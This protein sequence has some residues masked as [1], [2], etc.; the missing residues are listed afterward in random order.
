[1]QSY[2]PKFK[3]AG[4]NRAGNKTRPKTIRDYTKEMYNEQTDEKQK[5]EHFKAQGK[6]H[7]HRKHKRTNR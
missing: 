6:I 7:R 4:N 5:Q 2:D 1:M 3:I